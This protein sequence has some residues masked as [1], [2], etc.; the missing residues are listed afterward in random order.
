MKR[1]NSSFALAAGVSL[2]LHAAVLT[3]LPHYAGNEYARD[4]MDAA[5]DERTAVPEREPQPLNPPMEE[6]EMGEAAGKGYA[7]N[8]VPDA[9]EAT[10]PEADADQG[11]LSLDPS[12]AGKTGKDAATASA[13]GEGSRRGQPGGAPAALVAAMTDASPAQ[14]RTPFG[15]NLELKLPRATPRPAKP[16]EIVMPDL[17]SPAPSSPPAELP[18]AEI[19]LSIQVPGDPA[20]QPQPPTPPA[21]VATASPQPATV[22]TPPTG[23]TTTGGSQQPAADPAR[24]S[25]SESDPF[26]RL[27]VATF[28]D[29][30]LE[31]RFGRKVKTRKPKLLVGGQ[32]ALLALQRA[33]VVLNIQIDETGKVT[34]VEVAKSSGSN[35]IDQPTRVAVYDWWFEPKVNASGL[36]VADEV[37]FTISWR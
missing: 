5:A 32:V 28:R 25:D 24:M 7:S 30:R 29:G 8:D 26:S 27:G 18:P 10:A 12:G 1:P 6:F 35:E 2:T 31:I 4:M 21:Q 14:S 19:A 37:Q 34:G 9:A 33:R 16:A 22:L 3:V 23:S 36:A 15:V 20:A 11:Y 13:D 17:I